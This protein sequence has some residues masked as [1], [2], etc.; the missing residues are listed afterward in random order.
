[1]KN[2]KLIKILWTFSEKELTKLGEF[3][4]SPFFNH[5]QKVIPLLHYFQKIF[6]EPPVKA[7]EKAVIF[8][9]CYPKRAFE[10]NYLRKQFSILYQLVQQFLI[11]QELE[12]AIFEKEHALLRQYEKRNLT[13]LFQLQHRAMSKKLI[14]NDSQNSDFFFQQY[15][16]ANDADAYFGRQQKR[17]FDEA[18]QQKMDSFDAY[19][20]IEKLK[21]CCEM[22]NRRKIVE[23]GYQLNFVEEILSFFQKSSSLSEIPIIKI[24]LQIFNTL[25][26]EEEETHFE[27][28]SELL[29]E[30]QSEFSQKEAIGMYRYAQ[31]YCIRRINRGEKRYFR[32]LFELFQKQLTH[33]INLPNGILSADDYK[34]IV[35]VGLS[36]GE[37]DWVKTFIYDY[38]NALLPASR[39]NVFHYNLANYYYG[40]KDYDS[41]I[42]LLNTVQFTDDYYEISGKI[43]LAKTY[44]LQQEFEAIYYLIDAFKL[45]LRRNKRVATPYK[46]SVTNF[47]IQ[48]KKVSK[49]TEDRE[50]ILSADFDRKFKKLEKRILEV[51]PITDKRWLLIQLNK[52]V[53]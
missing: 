25:R 52:L 42:Q 32:E 30:Y 2:S 40:I 18:L 21:G 26:E 12:N 35:T 36:L 8:K 6:P 39:E 22:M 48:L 43:I 27:K 19:Y 37:A 53:S 33:K 38:K 34:N 7:L 51:Q 20:L 31:N 44:F 24:Y 17:R 29:E 14:T 46:L 47:L 11:Q 10:E 45:N 3:V 50:Y 49:L 28:L 1:M 23:G 16:L 5:H 9:K 41:A 15:Q 13:P 4:H